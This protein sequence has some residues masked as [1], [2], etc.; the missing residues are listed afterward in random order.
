MTAGSRCLLPITS[1]SGATSHGCA[2]HLPRPRWGAWSK[3]PTEAQAEP[4][5]ALGSP[6]R[7]LSSDKFIKTTLLSQGLWIWSQREGGRVTWNRA[8]HLQAKPSPCEKPPFVISGTSFFVLL[9]HSRQYNIK[10]VSGVQ[11]S[12]ESISEGEFPPLTSV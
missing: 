3:L 4:P 6:G 12:E 1:H 9:Q 10:F 11:Y 8:G 7:P 2:T 5:G